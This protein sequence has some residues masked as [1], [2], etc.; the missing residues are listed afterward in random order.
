MSMISALWSK[1]F[2]VWHS[3]SVSC[4]RLLYQTGYGSG[5]EVNEKSWQSKRSQWDVVA[6]CCFYRKRK[7]GIVMI[8]WWKT[9]AAF[10]HV[11]WVW[12]N[13]K[14]TQENTADK[15]TEQFV[16]EVTSSGLTIRSK[17]GQL[18]SKVHP[19]CT[20]VSTL[21]IPDKAAQDLKLVLAAP[22][23]SKDP[24]G[25][26]AVAQSL[27][28]GV[29]CNSGSAGDVSLSGTAG[30]LSKNTSQV[31]SLG[32]TSHLLV[33]TQPPGFHWDDFSHFPLVF[34]LLQNAVGTLVWCHCG[35]LTFV[36]CVQNTLWFP[37]KAL[38][39]QCNQEPP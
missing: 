24:V 22:S 10:K 39:M 30:S 6:M 3:V 13:N 21:C 23:V 32:S 18:Q 9:W 33:L 1:T 5:C 38:A 8:K 36:C 27:R 2:P 35:L 20:H 25:P 34:C 11:Q 17:Q 31:S 15:V 4:Q 29:C 7:N 14:D 16:L 12:G 19:S 37:P 28:K 26:G